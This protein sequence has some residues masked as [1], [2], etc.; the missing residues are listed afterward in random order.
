MQ[1]GIFIVFE[2]GDV[3]KTWISQ[4]R[5]V[6]YII[7]ISGTLWNPTT[8]TQKYSHTQPVGICTDGCDEA[9]QENTEANVSSALEMQIWSQQ[10]YAVT[11]SWV[12][13]LRVCLKVTGSDKHGWQCPP[14]ESTG[15]SRLRPVQRMARGNILQLWPQWGSLLGNG[16]ETARGKLLL[17][18]PEAGFKSDSLISNRKLNREEGKNLL[19]DVSD[20]FYS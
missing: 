1:S 8:R 2:G 7:T 16:G 11:R 10:K 13:D 9:A 19:L 15:T 4:R 12:T 3:K 6:R 18:L 5:A 14:P 17:W 20:H